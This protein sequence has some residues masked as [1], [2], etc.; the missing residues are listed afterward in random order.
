MFRPNISTKLLVLLLLVAL[1][2]MGLLS[3][4]WY[5]TTQISL[6][7]D[8]VASQKIQTQSDS[9]RV[10][11]YMT[12]KVNALIIHSQATSVQSFIIT[13]ATKDLQSLLQ[14]DGDIQHLTLVNQKGI[15]AIN[16]DRSGS[17]PTGADVSSEDAFRAAT[18]LAG[19]EYISP[20]TFNSKK[21]PMVTIAAP[22]VQ[23]TS[24]QDLT[25]LSTAADGQ[26]RTPDQ[27]SGVLIETVNLNNLWQSV[28]TKT[29]SNGEYAYV[30]DSEGA[31]IGYP[32]TSFSATHQSLKQAAPVAAF[33]ANPTASP[34]PTTMTS[35]RGLKVLSSYAQVSRTNWGVISEVPLSTVFAASNRAAAV[36]AAILAIATAVIT[37]VSYVVSRRV[38]RP[39][40][41]LAESAEQ[42]S[43]GKLDTRTSV[44]SRDEIGS[45]SQAFN[46]MAARLATILQQA[47]AESTKANVILNNVSEG[48]LALD[49]EGNIMLANV[50]AA[51]FIGELP[52]NIIRKPMDDLYHWTVNGKPFHPLQTGVGIYQEIM[53]TNENKRVYFVDMLVNPI[54]DDPTGINCIL[55]ILDKS[56][57]R[58]LENMKVDFVSM[59]AHELR[60]PMTS[61]RGYVDLI[62]HE[63]SFQPSELIQDYVSHIDA[64]SVQ[65]VGLINNL[66]NV[67]RIER[68]VLTLR[69]DK[70]DWAEL[71][72]KA[73]ADQ[74]FTAKAK[75]LTLTYEGPKEG[76]FLFADPLAITEVI[77]NLV[78]NAINHTLTGG[79]IAVT[80][81][82]MGD[83]VV[84]KVIDNGVGI[85]EQ[86][87]PHLFTKFYRARSSLTSGSGGTGLG[88]FISRS[89]VE[90]HDGRISAESEEG[91]GST[92]TVVL[93]TFDEET[94]NREA[95]VKSESITRKHGWIIKNTSRRR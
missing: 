87:L 17:L 95:K 60:T 77:N 48:I 14:Q 73:I 35:E 25:N 3:V 31:L 50:A 4:Y 23:Y 59:A 51:V 39:I 81:V 61:I 82:E 33:L 84:T 89:I 66:L 1:I 78:S 90:M 29:A 28:F 11:Q 45:L 15:V 58:E 76:V 21:Q 79:T 32:D 86:S 63:K 26:I 16:F 42:I 43:L 54:R 2:P 68:G 41:Q 64:S 62:Q 8:A 9:Y 30:V 46:R 85:S 91:K 34:T 71:V 55:T 20:V 44:E 6:R 75:S 12:D 94:Y 53:L 80:V 13:P 57:E 69:R 38:T 7:S 52:Q 22:L 70:I 67:S 93:P 74:Q 24:G 56:K 27:I 5:R 92:F 65:L 36:G 49:G 19:K 47:V 10:D 83:E 40:R 37:V 18:Y 72:Q 88:L